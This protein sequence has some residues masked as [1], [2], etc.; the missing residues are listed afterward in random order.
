[1]LTEKFE[2]EILFNPAR[3]DGQCCNHLR[4]ITAFTDVERI[5]SHLIQLF[6]GKKKEYVSNIKVEVILGMTK[7]N[8][9]T[10]RKHKK[11][12]FSD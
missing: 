11:N 7:G 6:D 9:L 1:M 8:G 4:I 3:I 2:D 5:S 12:M 10:E